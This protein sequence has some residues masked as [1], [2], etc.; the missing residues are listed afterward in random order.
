MFGETGVDHIVDAID[1]ETRLGDVGGDDG[2]S[3]TWRREF[4]DA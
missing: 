4:K 2:F 3:R 1:S